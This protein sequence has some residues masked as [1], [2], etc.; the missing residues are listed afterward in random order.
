MNN[1]M[2]YVSNIGLEYSFP[3]IN[4]GTINCDPIKI[5]DASLLIRQSE[6]RLL[7]SQAR[8]E[9]ELLRTRILGSALEMNKFLQLDDQIG[10]QEYK[11]CT[12][13]RYRQQFFAME[14][15]QLPIDDGQSNHALDLIFHNFDNAEASGRTTLILMRDHYQYSWRPHN[16]GMLGPTG[17]SKFLV[18][19][20][21][22]WLQDGQAQSLP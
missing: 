6:H 18:R 12:S 21:L 17:S 7:N 10:I 9:Y 2:S 20:I 19:S 14:F 11:L 22:L 13:L 1:I 15:K 5:D 4:Q 3:P 8:I 16:P